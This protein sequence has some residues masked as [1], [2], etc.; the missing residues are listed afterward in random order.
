M[1]KTRYFLEVQTPDLAAGE[2]E[3]EEVKKST[4]FFSPATATKSGSG[5]IFIA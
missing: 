2:N 1:D 4:P 3:F 5:F